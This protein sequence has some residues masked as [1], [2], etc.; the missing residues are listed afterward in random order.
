M[1]RRKKSAIISI[2]V[3]L[4]AAAIVPAFHAQDIGAIVRV[5]PVPDGAYYGVDGV[6]YNHATS[7]IWPKGSKHTLTVELSTQGDSSTNYQFDSWTVGSTTLPG[8]MV[9]VTADS[10]I[11]EYHAQFVTT[12]ALRLAFFACPDPAHCPSPGTVYMGGSKIVSDQVLFLNANASVDLLAV[13]NDGYVFNGWEPGQNQT[14]S[15]FINHVTMKS[16][17]VVYPRFV[18]ARRVNLVTD[19]PGLMVLADRTPVSTPIGMDW[20]TDTTH[21]LG[22]LT[23]QE[24]RNGGYWAFAGWSDGGEATHAYKVGSSTTPVTVTARYV[25]LAVTQISTLPPGLKIS[26]DG[27]DNWPS[28][29]FPWGIGETHR[30]EAPAEQT[31]ATGHVWKFRSWSNGGTAAQTFTVP[32]DAG[33]TG[34][35][36]VATYDPVAHLI[37]QSS[38][39]GLRVTIDENECATPCDIRRAVG[40]AVRLTAPAS[41]A[42]GEGVR[43][44]F[45][46][47][48]GSGNTSPNWSITLG[49][50][51]LTLSADYQI[52]NRLAAQ[53]DPPA[54]VTWRM[55][56]PSS[57]G[58]YPAETPVT[59]AVTP[60][61]GYR[62]RTWNGDLSGNSPSGVLSMNVP[63]RIQA[64]LDRV[65]YIAPAG[66]TNAAGITPQ[67]LVA[68]GSIVSVFGENLANALAVGPDS[69]LSQTLGGVTVRAGD[70]LLPLFFVSPSQINLLL[71]PE[72]AEGTQSLIVSTPGLPDVQSAFTV[73]RAAPGIFA[74]S[75][76]GQ[77]FAVAAHEDGSAVSADSPA[78]KGELLTVYGTGFGPT[79]RPRP[80]GFAVPAS[81]SFLITDAV[82]VQLGDVALTPVAAFAAVGRIGVDAV[83]F[84][85][86]EEAPSGSLPLRITING[87]DSNSVVLP[88][89]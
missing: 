16:P 38:M 23:P 5:I 35:R 52:M 24:D 27:R 66:V 89:L 25:P 85:V 56:P 45:N 3:A 15:G 30:I 53:S 6:F 49:A 63:R 51:P 2:T 80:Q 88:I 75:L 60:Q 14:I 36:L 77:S 22:G 9:N 12:Y 42:L 29:N 78:R 59:V 17:T 87:Q 1:S 20:G 50:D 65:P 83:Q 76:D 62:F 47:W 79:D 64:M 21:T 54:G 72:M 68:P 84:R 67:P 86:G 33:G 34:A 48:P 55:Q 10:G 74:Q 32:D 7:F 40:S 8:N 57:D 71:P 13:P 11:I 73:V 43:G 82:N 70:R 18:T 61:P 28:I 19:P 81:P 31:D 58:Y 46:G 26:V 39:Q 44:D 41:L 4:L 69:P 37:V